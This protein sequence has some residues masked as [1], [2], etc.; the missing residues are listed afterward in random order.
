[1]TLTRDEKQAQVQDLTANMQRASSVMFA[2]YI[3][4]NVANISKLR[5]QLKEKKAD[6]KVAKKTLMDIAMKNAKLPSPDP[7]L[8]DGPVGCIFSF[9]DPL[10]GA[11]VAFKFGKDHAQVELIGGIF[12]GKLLSKQEAQQFAELP[13]REVLL[14]MFATMLCSPLT[15]F[16]GICSSPL[17]AFARAIHELSKKKTS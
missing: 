3:G 2:H 13:P 1:M 14:T 9:G 8:L 5:R 16:V 17:S 6:M 15:Q 7:T 12:E 4:L 11:Q 10:S